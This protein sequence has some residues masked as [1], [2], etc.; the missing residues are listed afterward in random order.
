MER[1]TLRSAHQAAHRDG[2]QQMQSAGILRPAAEHTTFPS[3]SHLRKN[4][5]RLI[6]CF[7]GQSRFRFQPAISRDGCRAS[8]AGQRVGSWALSGAVVRFHRPAYSG[9]R[10]GKP[11]VPAVQKQRFAKEGLAL[12]VMVVD[13]LEGFTRRGVLANPRVDALVPKQASFLSALPA[14]SRVVF[15]ADA[16]E[17]GDAELKR[18]PVH[19]LKDTP[20]AQVRPELL[21]AAEKAGAEINIIRKRTFSGFLDTKLDSVL[22]A[23]P[24]KSWIQLSDL[25][26]LV[27]VEGVGAEEGGEFAELWTVVALMM[28]VAVG[29]GGSMLSVWR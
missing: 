27:S 3:P 23:A 14:R 24:D 17:T 13:M 29:W 6:L 1:T 22:A 5:G 4:T 25:D 2:A 8:S 7:I 15:L 26:L 12:Q 28:I 11:P 21:A 10:W 18:F 9:A 19:C 20:E 16:H